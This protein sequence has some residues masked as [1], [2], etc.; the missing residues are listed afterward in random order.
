MNGDLPPVARRPVDR[1]GVGPALGLRR[2]SLRLTRSQVGW[3]LTPT[4]EPSLLSSQ[5][6]QG[7]GHPHMR[8]RPD[9]ISDWG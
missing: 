6:Q 8:S 5:V 9:L 3:R 1:L 7:P 4:R 2:H